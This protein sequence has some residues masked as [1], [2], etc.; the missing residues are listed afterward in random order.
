MYNSQ[1]LICSLI[2]ESS[3]VRQIIT[4]S[5]KT[6]VIVFQLC[7]NP[8]KQ[9]SEY[10]INNAQSVRNITLIVFIARFSSNGLLYMQ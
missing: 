4:S 6:S 5:S 1:I 9:E 10:A 2:D 7:G 8:A 3:F